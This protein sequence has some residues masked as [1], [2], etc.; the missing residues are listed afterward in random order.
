MSVL[1][2]Q[3]P[4]KINLYLRV[5][6]K[7]PENYHLLDSLVVFANIYDVIEISP[8]A[9]ISVTVTGENAALVSPSDNTVLKA[10]T[11]LQSHFGIKT[12]AQILLQK[13]LPVGAG[14]GGGS[15]DAA[16]ALKLLI[17]LWKIDISEHDLDSI[18][19]SIGADV[20]ACL[21]ATAVYMSSIGEIIDKAPKLPKL[22][23]V[24]VGTGRPLLTKD[25]F[26][27]YKEK[28]V[29]P[30]VPPRAFTFEMD[31]LDFLY[32]N[33]NDLQRPAIELMPEIEDVLAALTAEEGCL[34]ARMSGS[35]ATCF[36]LFEKRKFAEEAAIKLSDRHP[37][38]WVKVAQYE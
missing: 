6:G 23:M 7:T 32:R 9:A 22:H 33:G 21:R 34:L 31:L 27:R 26:A 19:L 24:L 38:W 36:G 28:F 5:T 37:K 29:P 1:S 15:S 16:A 14:I 30:V 4:A 13:N 12:G 8:A 3:A 17:R 20:P 2:A 10:A 25:V 35:G 11:A 18:A